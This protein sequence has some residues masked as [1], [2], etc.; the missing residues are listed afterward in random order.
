MKPYVIL[1]S[2]IL[3][4]ILVFAF[5]SISGTSTIRGRAVDGKGLPMADLTVI[6]R[7]VQ[8]AGPHVRATTDKKGRFRFRHVA[9]ARYEVFPLAE[10]FRTSTKVIVESGPEPGKYRLRTP[11]VVRIA[12]SPDGIIFDSRSGLQWLPALEPTMNW[13]EAARRVAGLSSGWRLPT[14]SELRSIYDESYEGH[15][16]PL[17]LIERDWVWA[18][19]PADGDK[20]W[21]FSF[22]N[23]YEGT[24]PKGWLLTRG[25]TLAVRDRR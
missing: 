3:L 12:M 9:P 1:L 25:R 23:E 16:D 2:A 10:K 5:F 15:A 6:A 7:Q 13:F 8:P 14:R 19:E 21:F 17:F 18:S 24:H 4:C 22:E 20:A 11:L